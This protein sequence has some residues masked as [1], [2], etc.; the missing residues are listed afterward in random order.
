MDV[1]IENK[2]TG[3]DVIPKNWRIDCIGNFAHTTAGGT[4]STKNPSFWGGN[5]LWMNSGELNNKFIYNVEGR[6]TELGLNNSSTKYIPEKCVLIGLA[7]QGKT[8]GTA[9]IN[10][11][12][13]C[14]NQSIAAIFPNDKFIPEYL[15]YY[16]DSKY[17]NLRDLSSGGS[18]RGGLN[19]QIINSIHI[20]LPPLPEQRAIA[21]ALS[22]VDALITALD[23]LIAKKRAIKQ[24]V[25]QALLT[26]KRRLPG[27]SGEWT[28]YTLGQLFDISG[29]FSASREQLSSEGYCYLHYGDIHLSN[30]TYIDVQSE[31]EEIPKLN[32]PL[33]KVARNSLL[34]DGDIVFVDASEDDNGASK[35]MV[36]INKGNTPFISGLHTIVAKKKTDL[37]DHNYLRYCFQIA[38]IKRQFRFYA[39][40]TKVTGISK[41]NIKKIILTIP[42]FPEQKEISTILIDHDL[43][44]TGLDNT[45]NKSKT[46]KQGMMQ[47][48]LTGRTRLV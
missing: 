13:L 17:Q 21:K 39:V 40:G 27:F 46:I 38:D 30:K 15:Y 29:G 9:A 36:I 4:P 12:Q 37:M 1:I 3:I 22:D 41:T 16:L 8:R 18:G 11:V 10:F 7:G 34:D 6:I 14:T 32:I 33:N 48:L 47:E 43:E 26:G 5:F 42:S 35:H 45:L 2:K 20:P 31:Y 23:A 24:G 25:M 19:L 28:S 44:I